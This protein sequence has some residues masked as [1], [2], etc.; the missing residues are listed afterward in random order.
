MR[1]RVGLERNDERD[2]L[3]MY[4]DSIMM[5]K[6]LEEELVNAFLRRVYGWM[7]VGLGVSALTA[8]GVARSPTVAGTL[9]MNQTVFW[10]LLLVELALVFVLSF[11]V[12]RIQAASAAR[13][14]ILYSALTG[15]T[16]SVLLLAY[17]GASVAA[18]FLVTA[19]MFVATAA[20]GSAARKSLA[21]AGHF[22][23]MALAGLVLAS[24]IGL[25]WH[26]GTLQVMISMVGVIVFT[27]LAAVDAQRLKQMALEIRDEGTGSFAV[28]GALAIYLDLINFFFSVLRLTGRRRN[29]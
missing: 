16:S 5:A 14:F 11:R 9:I 4:P 18:A 1:R 10:G 24:V 19:G 29:K 3:G 8:F 2:P 12:D 15:A 13:M 23:F 7:F 20:L 28:A 27:G 26:S 21:G 25:L 17:T 22:F 6:E